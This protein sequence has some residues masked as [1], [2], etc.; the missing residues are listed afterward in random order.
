MSIS[1]AQNF[2]QR[3]MA[4]S[5]LV[6]RINDAPDVPAVQ[7][8]LT[9]EGYSFNADE[10]EEAYTHLLTQCQFEEQADCLK[11]VRMWW[12]FL[13]QALMKINGPD[14]E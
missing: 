7:D 12:E 14:P 13:G 5:D 11:G 9:K 8:I 1:D 2:I 3:A 10:F 4:E 6:E